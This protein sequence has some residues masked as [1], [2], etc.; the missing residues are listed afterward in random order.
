MPRWLVLGSITIGFLAGCGGGDDLLLPGAGDPASVTIVQG[1]QQNGRVGEL[2]AQPVVATVAD[3]SGRPVEGAT[4]VFQ[5]MDPVP[6]AALEPDTTTT[7]TDGAASTEVR[8]GTQPGSQTGQ[9]SALDADGNPTAQAR[10]T[11][12]AV[13]ES[14]NGIVAVA[15]DSQSAPVGTTLPQPLVVQVTDAFGNP[16]PGVTV[17]WTA[18]GGGSVS[19]VSTV[20][21]DDG[22]TS[23][24]RTLGD[25]AGTQRTLASADGLAGSPVTFVH[26]ATAGAAEGVAIVAGNGQTG[27]VGQKLPTDLVVEVRDAD[28]NPVPGVAVTWVV[29]E[30]GGSV[31]PGTSTT[32]GGG[33]ASTSWTLGSSPGGN[34]VNAVVSG[35]GVAEFT[36]TAT[37]GTPSRLSLIVQPSSTATSGVPLAQAPVV[38]LLDPSGNPAPQS[39]V[40]VKVAIATGG[41]SL[42]GTTSRG[43]DANGRAT[44]DGLVISGPAGGRTLRFTADGYEPVTSA[45]IN[46]AAAPQPV[47]AIERQPP[48]Q[49]TLGQ[50]LD[51]APR[52]RLRSAAGDEIHAAGVTITAGI[53]SG[54]GTLSNAA[55]V[56]DGQGVAEFTGITVSGDPGTR[57]LAFTAADYASVTSNPFDVVAPVPVPDPAHSSVTAEPDTVTAGGAST[58]TVLVRDAGGVPLA[59]IAVVLNGGSDPHVSPTSALTDGN[60]SATFTFT[61][62]QPTSG[63][64]E[65]NTVTA[66]AGDLTLGSATITVLAA[67]T[68]SP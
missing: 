27:P 19:E 8:L 34:T 13:S 68:T 6:G 31:D 12:T 49:A 42:G 39:G 23:V 61:S 63:G 55:A 54:G 9:V 40:E 57:T 15:G 47:L 17:A 58:V 14:A 2:L 60:G 41:G 16:I 24:E 36:A 38:Q 20:T 53:A 64:V 66:T 1:D 46:V 44:F 29:G 11:V 7:D 48:P 67:P 35:I 52:V 10:F 50:P 51:P 5:L 18:D 56:T 4:V 62:T 65:V 37:G 26:T 30:G 59:G 25:A 28:H 33:R 32:D 3:A 43:T 21:G 22:Q 45:V